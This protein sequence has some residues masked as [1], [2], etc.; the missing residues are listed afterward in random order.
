MSFVGPSN[1]TLHALHH[2]NLAGPQQLVNHKVL[3]P[4]ALLFFQCSLLHPTL[5]H[6]KLAKRIRIGL[7]PINFI[8]L[9]TLPLRYSFVPSNN[10]NHMLKVGMALTLVNFAVR[11]LD[12]GLMNGPVYLRAPKTVNG[13]QRWD[14]ETMDDRSY[15]KGQEDEPFKAWKVGLWSLLH[16]SS[17]RGL[18]FSWGPASAAKTGRPADLIRRM[19]LLNLP[20]SLALAFNVL[21]R[22]SPLGTPLSALLSIGIPHL[23]GLKLL[24]ESLHTACFGIYL[25]CSS[26]VRISLVT[27]I[28]IFLHKL[29]TRFQSSDLVLQFFDPVA[30]PPAFNSPHK[31]AS[32]ADFWAHGWHTMFK[33]NFVVAGGKPT[34][35]IMKKLGASVRIQHLVGL[36]G[37]FT[38]S[39]V[40]HEYAPWAVSPPSHLRTSSFYTAFPGSF[41]FFIVQPLA[42]LIEPYVIPLIPKRLGGGRLWTFLFLIITAYPFRVQYVSES[43]IHATVPPLSEWSWF[44]ILSPF[45]D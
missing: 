11:S 37:I 32:V 5:A 20:L 31:V 12:W 36:F 39:A 15:Q 29:A 30:Y 23:P 22:D 40:I 10:Q 16:L 26:D 8:L 13:V 41:F 7:T 43:R 21:V 25:A 4:L 24:S 1:N 3:V 18:Q 6:S 33:R 45:K 44:Y 19:I 35:W 9:V 28:V 38:A 17:L 27:I 42:I 14:K 34:V 2:Q